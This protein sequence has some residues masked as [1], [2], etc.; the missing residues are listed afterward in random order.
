MKVE[1]QAEFDAAIAAGK[2]IDIYND[3]T[4][5]VTGASAPNISIHSSST[6]MISIWD[7][8][9]PNIYTWGSS[10]PMISTRDSS[11][12][13]IITIGR[14]APTISTRESSAPTI[15][16]LSSSAPNIYTWGRSAPRI[17][18]QDS[19]VPTIYT[20]DSSTPTIYKKGSR[21]PKIATWLSP[22]ARDDLWAVL[23]SAPAE[24]LGVREALV[25]G[26]VNGSTYQG[27]C[28]CLVGTLEK[29]GV[30]ISLG[31]DVSRPAEQFF[32]GIRPGDTPATSDLAKLAVQ[33]IDELLA[34]WGIEVP[35]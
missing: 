27:E 19:S 32:L 35:A 18:I 8:S 20:Q 4:Y 24:I 33:W 13:R 6:P 22:I 23:C 9:A 15:S 21:A 28:A 31:H 3:E 29:S 1:N 7:R 34:N 2:S 16:T 26:L 17:N 5:S 14:S 11:T 12:A 30:K 10:A 25:Q